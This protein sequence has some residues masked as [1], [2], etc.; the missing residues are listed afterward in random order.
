MTCG[1]HKSLD[2]ARIPQNRNLNYELSCGAKRIP[3][4]DRSLTQ[5][6]LPNTEI[7]YF[8]RLRRPRPT[9][10][11]AADDDDDDFSRFLYGM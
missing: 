8:S 6:I 1:G 7:V 3:Q 11:C 2:M 9:E 4:A 10:V 5:G